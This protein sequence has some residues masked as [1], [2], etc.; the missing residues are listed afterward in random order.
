MSS[1]ERKCPT[2]HIGK[3]K[4]TFT[5]DGYFYYC[6]HCGGITPLEDVEGREAQARRNA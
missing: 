2:C 6:R 4:L 1:H 5:R 3:L